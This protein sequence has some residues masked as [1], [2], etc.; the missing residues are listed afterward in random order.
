M[1]TIVLCISSLA[2]FYFAAT[3]LPTDRHCVSRSF[4]WSPAS[5]AI[6]YH[7]ENFENVDFFTVSPYFGLEQTEAIERAW[8]QLLP[9][10]IIP[11]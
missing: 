8:G 5:A 9:G 1:A 11:W 4:S 7:W 2:I 10:S 3:G 6:E